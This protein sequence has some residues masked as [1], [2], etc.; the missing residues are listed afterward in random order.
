MRILIFG[1]DGMLGHR[2]LAHLGARH[3]TRVTL[4][5][6]LA[7]YARHGLF[8]RDN[9]FDRTDVR[10]PA[11]VAAVVSGFRPDAVV[12]AAGIVKQRLEA[13]EL[14]LSE[15]VNARFPHRLAR[16]ASDHG[17]RL[18]HLST[19]C[20]FSGEKGNY[21]ESDPPDPVDVYGKTKLEGEVSAPGAITLRTSMI[22]TELDRK[23]GLVE[24]FL[25]QRG[26]TVPGYRKAIFSGF[27][28]AELARIIEMLLVR[29]PDAHGLYHASAAP[30]SK[31]DLLQGLERRLSLGV[32]LA[33]DDAVTCDRSLDSSRFR[34]AF[35]YAPPSW[36]AMLDELAGSIARGAGA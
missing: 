29:H 5:R 2:L 23:G 36:D 6:D 22:G 11:R 35:G 28:T 13:H 26:R 17:A 21:A 27:I 10:D 31:L 32:R 15:E 18:V 34:A 16:L 20:V 12:N 30:I 19:D 1:G 24:W 4:R 25:S 33:P 7:D 9:V 3:E 8:H 14:S